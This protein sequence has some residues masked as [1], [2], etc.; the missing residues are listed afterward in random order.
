MNTNTVKNHIGYYVSLIA[1]LVLGIVLV[2]QT[3][4]NLQL[5]II[6]AIF[7]VFF[8]VGWALLH[9]GLHHRLTTK[10]VL[11]YVLIAG[12]VMAILLFLFKGNA[13]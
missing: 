1:I 4:Y 2:K 6:I 13:L 12:L 7:T 9:Q 10:V 8:Y 5:Q 11:E 3:A